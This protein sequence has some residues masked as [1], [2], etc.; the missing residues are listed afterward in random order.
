[1]LSLVAILACTVSDSDDRL[2]CMCDN[3]VNVAL[4]PCGHAVLCS[5]CARDP[6]RCPTCRVSQPAIQEDCAYFYFVAFFAG[7]NR[8][9]TN[10]HIVLS[11][12]CMC[13]FYI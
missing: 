6:K 13:M 5:E 12:C 4:H 10:Y 7:A 8:K 11:M 3:E 2:C 9:E 1:M